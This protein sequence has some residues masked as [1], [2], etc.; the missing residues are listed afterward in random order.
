MCSDLCAGRAPGTPGGISARL[1]VVEAL[2]ARGLHVSEQPI[3][4]IGGANVLAALPGQSDRW[5]LVAAHYDHLGAHDGAMFRGA[6]DNAAVAI[7]VEVAAALARERPAGRGV[8]VATFDSEEP[9]HFLTPSMGSMCFLRDPPVPLDRI[10]PMICMDLVGDERNRSTSRHCCPSVADLEAQA[11]AV[12]VL[13][14]LGWLA[15]LA[16]WIASQLPVSRI[17]PSA[18]AKLKQVRET[19][20]NRRQQDFAT[21]ARAPRGLEGWDLFGKRE[22]SSDKESFKRLGHSSPIA[23]KWR[24]AY[25]TPQAD[26]LTRARDILAAPEPG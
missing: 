16:E 4:R 20:W 24:I 10:D 21:P 26:F 5:V 19:A 2:R 3:P 8:L 11:T 12:R 15:E 9:P 1:V 23:K 6:D 14:R 18:S 7:L 22:S 25:A 17:H 13:H